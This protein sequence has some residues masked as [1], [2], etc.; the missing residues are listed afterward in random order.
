MLR[1]QAIGH[2]DADHAVAHGEQRDIVV[3][4]KPT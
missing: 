1:R 4:G 2:I 3:V